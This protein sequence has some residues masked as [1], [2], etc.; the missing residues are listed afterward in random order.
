M[1]RH[2][3]HRHLFTIIKLY[4]LIT[5]KE[6]LTM[7][8]FFLLISMFFLFSCDSSKSL[9]ELCK[10]NPEICQE[11]G[12]D[13]WCK[14]ERVDVALERI[15]L[16]NKAQELVK[17]QLLVAYEGYIKCMSLA[18][19]IQHIKLKEKTTMR[20]N[21]LFKAQAYM[22][23]LAAETLDSSHP[24]LLFYHWSRELD[25]KALAQF[26]TLEGS[27]QL[28]NSISQ[29]HLATY[30]V[31]KDI[32]KTLGLLFHSLELHRP[33]EKLLPEVFQTLT[34]IFTNKENPKQA[35]IWLKVFQLTQEKRDEQVN[36]T[37]AQYAQHYNLNNEFLNQVAENTLDKIEQGKFIAPS[38]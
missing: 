24:H 16:K 18:S 15:A 37:L 5:N 35:Y 31:K 32:N 22:S 11:F 28:E 4:F 26:L 7:K 9:A 17:Y 30:Y 33:N 23:E 8:P 27:A 13:S 14:K 25:E 38:Y 2:R 29:Y 6:S 1:F 36:K 21:N 10:E 19:Q 34:T 12:N 20:K 3:L